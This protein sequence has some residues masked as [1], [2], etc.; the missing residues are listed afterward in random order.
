MPRA[1]RPPSSMAPGRDETLAGHGNG[2]S[3][4]AQS[5]SN[6]QSRA[7]GLSSL[8]GSRSREADWRVVWEGG[9]KVMGWRASWPISSI[10]AIAGCAGGVERY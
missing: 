7:D 4:A 3:G 6:K 5:G 10:A 1:V 9:R 8:G 2:R